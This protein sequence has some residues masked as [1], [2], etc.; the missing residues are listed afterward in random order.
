MRYWE[1]QVSYHLPVSQELL[2]GQ[3]VLERLVV[4]APP[5]KKE[6]KG[7]SVKGMSG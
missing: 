6:R 1:I 2:V 5:M 3:V 7:T 4:P